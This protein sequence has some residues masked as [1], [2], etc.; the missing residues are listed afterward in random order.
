MP[1]N[2]NKREIYLNLKPLQHY[3]PSCFISSALALISEADFTE[4][5]KKRE[6]MWYLLS[7]VL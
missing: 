7:V 1:S 6:Q 5:K 3:S 2:L 4:K